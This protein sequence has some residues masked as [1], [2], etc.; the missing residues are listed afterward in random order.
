MFRT[1]KAFIMKHLFVLVS[2][3]LI[4]SGCS[5]WYN[6]TTYFNVYYNASNIFDDVE[7]Q[8]A[9]Q[10]KDLFTLRDERP[11]SQVSQSL[12]KVIEKLSKILQFDTKS[13]FVDDALLMIGKS[14][15]YQQDYQ[16]ALRKF[17]ELIA[18]FPQSELVLDAQLWTGKTQLRLRNYEQ[19]NKM[20]EQVMQSARQNERKEIL[21]QTY[22]EMVSYLM[23]IEKYTEAINTALELIKITDDSERNALISYEIGKLYLK[24]NQP[25]K[26]AEAFASVQKYSPDYKTDYYSRLEYGKVQRDLDK[27]EQALAVFKGI[28]KEKNFNEFLDLTLVETGITLIDLKKPYEAYDQLLIVDTTYKQTQSSGI[29][30]YY[31][32]ELMEY[33]FGKYDSASVYYG[34]VMSSSAPMEYT[35]KAGRK[36]QIFAK[37]QML[38]SQINQFNKMLEYINDSTAFVRDS[39]AYYRQK[40]EQDS[41]QKAAQNQTEEPNQFA[42]GRDSRGRGRNSRSGGER[43]SPSQNTASQ[44]GSSGRTEPPVKPIISADSVKSLLAKNEYELGGLFFTELDK[45]DSAYKYYSHIINEYPDNPF[46]ARTLYALGTYYLTM[47]DKPKADSLFEVV[48]NRY[49]TDRIVNAAADKLGKPLVDLKYDPAEKLYISAEDKMKEEKYREAV[50]S[51]VDISRQYPRSPFAPKALF[52]G[53][54]IFEN[55]LHRPDSAAAVYDSLLKKY[56]STIYSA[57]IRS[58]INVYGIEQKRLKAVQDSARAREEAAKRP[59]VP[60]RTDSLNNAAGVP[61]AGDANGLENKKLQQNID[62]ESQEIENPETGVNMPHPGTSQGDSVLTAPAQGT[63]STGGAVLP[64]PAAADSATVNGGSSG[65]VSDS[66]AAVKDSSKVSKKGK[67]KSGKTKQDSTSAGKQKQK[68]PEKDKIRP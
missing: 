56:P 18:T 11:Q 31:M 54:W 58:K 28:K 21:S 2:A 36:V 60:V 26:A 40:A 39:I 48:Y 24:T 63:D 25:E 6:F 4:F 23:A 38:A 59:P 67:A 34:K 30:N 8:I 32:A 55:K 14:F 51:F 53:G 17:T 20:L 64:P 37:Y 42:E 45:P 66:S 1:N 9:A 16:K 27:P 61:P 5:L 3:A 44:T 49:Q 57:R 52:A 47:N 13:A 19:G 12:T 10:R 22:V 68:Q 7:K 41:I 46:T 15:Y 35:Q 62:N 29:A 43:V 33:D 50:N 65:M